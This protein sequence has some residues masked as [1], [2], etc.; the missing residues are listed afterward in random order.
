MQSCIRRKQNTLDHMQYYAPIRAHNRCNVLSFVLKTELNSS[1]NRSK[2]K[3]ILCATCERSTKCGDCHA[4]GRQICRTL[5]EQC[6]TQKIRKYPFRHRFADSFAIKIV[7]RAAVVAPGQWSSVVA[8]D[9][10]SRP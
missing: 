10:L 5:T 4:N 3:Q 9:S 6:P 2:R 8:T 7:F 1:Y